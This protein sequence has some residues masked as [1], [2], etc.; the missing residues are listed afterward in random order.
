M[1][2]QHFPVGAA[3]INDPIPSFEMI[4]R[5]TDA[6][7]TIQSGEIQQII[8]FGQ[9]STGFFIADSP[10]GIA[11]EPFSDALCRFAERQ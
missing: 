8:S 6:V 1:A 7:V 10:P 9:A 3:V 4:E 11:G 5:D 2:F